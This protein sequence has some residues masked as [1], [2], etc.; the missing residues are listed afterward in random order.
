MMPWDDGKYLFTNGSDDSRENRLR[1]R[2]TRAF[3]K[4]EE[5]GVS[6]DEWQA[7]TLADRLFDKLIEH[8]HQTPEDESTGSRGRSSL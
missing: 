7:N 1:Q 5:D 4:A 3:E 2:I 8:F 6:L